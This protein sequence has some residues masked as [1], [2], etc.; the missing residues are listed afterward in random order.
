M[1]DSDRGDEKD[2]FWKVDP[3]I[4]KPGKHRRLGETLKDLARSIGKTVGILLLI[5]YPVLV[6]VLGVE[7]GALVFWGTLAGSVA[8]VGLLLQRLGY[9]RRFGSQDPKLLRQLVA[10]FLAF[11]VIASII[12]VASLWFRLGLRP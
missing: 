12:V 2:R 4:F 9:A 6:V 7:Y 1:G 8:V 3:E 5:A 10:L 11:A